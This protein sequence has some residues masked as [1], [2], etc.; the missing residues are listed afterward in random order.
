MCFN[1]GEIIA[2]IVDLLT[3]V[4]VIN[5]RFVTH[6]HLIIIPPIAHST[7]T[8]PIISLTINPTPP[9][10]LTITITITITH[11][12]LTLTPIFIPITHYHLPPPQPLL[13]PQPIILVPL[14]ILG[15][16]ANLELGDYLVVIFPPYYQ[17]Y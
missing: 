14:T 11:P 5:V 1:W 2:E 7:I 17:F 16:L 13:I 9:I 6:R 8:L 10:T 4:V 15:A 12:T 3:F